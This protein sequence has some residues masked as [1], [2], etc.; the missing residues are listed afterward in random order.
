[1]MRALEQETYSQRRGLSLTV[2][3]G[4][5]MIDTMHTR[6][7][8]LA[9]G[10][11]TRMNPVGNKTPEASAVPPTAERISN[12]ANNGAIPKVLTLFEGKPMIT[13]LLDAVARSGVD[14][15]PVIVTGYQADAVEKVLGD[16]YD[17]V[18][19][20]DQLGTGHAVACAEALIRGTAQNVM[21]LYGDHPFIKTGTIINLAALHEREGCPLSLTTTRVDDFDGWRAPFADFGRVVRDASG[22]IAAV[23]EMRDAT[24]AERA[25]QEIMPGFFCFSAPWLW[26]HLRLIANHNAKGEYYLTD[27]V[28]M[29][30]DEGACAA[31][32]P[33]SP[34]ESIGINTPAHLKLAG[35]SG[36]Q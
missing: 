7:V 32:L 25:I 15:R 34:Q 14:A 20:T 9:A 27:L 1:M 21:V 5:I 33:I 8:I 22:A 16:G 12:G 23:V 11:G 29:A 17:Y 24:P 36:L 10:K 3:Y 35:Q 18:R 2:A 4:I 6:I 19:Q 28:R 26:G 30:I 31:S 13:Y